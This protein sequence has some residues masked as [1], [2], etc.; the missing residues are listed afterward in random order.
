MKHSIGVIS[1]KIHK[2]VCT[3]EKPVTISYLFGKLKR[4][5][6]KVLIAIGWLYRSGFIDLEENGLRIYLVGRKCSKIPS[7]SEHPKIMISHKNVR[8][9]R[10]VSPD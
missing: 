8:Y 3:S 5:P 7:K 9:R 6:R 10:G 2:V 4:D 1:D